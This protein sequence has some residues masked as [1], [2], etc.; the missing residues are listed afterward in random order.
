MFFVTFEREPT[1]LHVF[2]TCDRQGRL[3]WLV[4][5]YRARGGV[6]LGIERW[7]EWFTRQIIQF[8]IIYA[9]SLEKA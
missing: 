6:A 3:A 7:S 5:G 4:P 2:G 9:A 1:L 8:Q